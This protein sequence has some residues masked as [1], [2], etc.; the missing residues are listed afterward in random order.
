[1]RAA[2]RLVLVLLV[3]VGVVANAQQQPLKIRITDAS[4]ASVEVTNLDL[5]YSDYPGGFG[6]YTPD[7][8]RSGIRI[9]QGTGRVTVP[10]A[11]IAV[12][13][14]QLQTVYFVQQ[15][16]DGE[17]VEFTESEKAKWEAARK[18]AASSGQLM[19]YSGQLQLA[20][21]STSTVELL[22]VSKNIT[23][24]TELGDYAISISNVRE[25]RPVK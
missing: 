1:M 11:S 5:D 24:N 14:V 3:G 2:T 25:I 15:K 7:H 17:R 10:W 23:G 21:G 13:T 18:G 9:R 12:L 19:K 8:E 6:W 4:G 20:S 16:D 22:P